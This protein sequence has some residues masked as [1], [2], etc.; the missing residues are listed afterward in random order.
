VLFVGIYEFL[1]FEH[2]YFVH[3]DVHQPW[4]RGYAYKELTT[5]LKNYYPEFKKIVITKANASPYIYILFYDKYDPKKYQQEGSP[6]DLDFSGF[7]KY[8]FVPYDCPL[9]AGKLGE[10]D[11]TGDVNTLYVNRGDC[12]DPKHNTRVLK[13]VYWEDGNPAFKLVQ[14]ISTDSGKIK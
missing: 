12:V 5:D 6:R 11:F 9:S 10:D 2:Q 7:D 1:Y 8:Y 14:Y 13:T 4:Y 3:Q